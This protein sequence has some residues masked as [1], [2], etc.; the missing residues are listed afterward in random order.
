MK[1]RELIRYLE[2]NGCKFLREERKHTVYCNPSNR[3]TSTVP[4]HTEIVDVLARKIC[5]ALQIIY[6][7]P[8]EDCRNA[9][10][11]FY[12][13]V[14]SD[15]RGNNFRFEYSRPSEFI[16]RKFSEI[17]GAIS[18]DFVTIY[19]QAFA[20]EQAGL[21]VICGTGYRK[22]LE[23]L[24]KDYLI[25]N[26]S[27]D[28]EKDKIKGEFLGKLIEKRID[29][30]QLKDIAKRAVWLGNDET[31]Y[32]RKWQDKDVSDLKSLID[33]TL[34]WVETNKLT[35]KLLQDMPEKE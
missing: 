31:H 28:A 11:G 8:N 3:K 15:P 1:R 34:H 23:F 12:G 16:P 29:H 5:K 14:F 22:A 7:C 6:R 32:E 10:I 17:I 35:E 18:P 30:P 27:E 20:A 25:S 19:N 26:V 21:T 33:L 24:V 13:R 4:R 9:F 2:A